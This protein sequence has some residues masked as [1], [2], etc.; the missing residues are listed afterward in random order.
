MVFSKTWFSIVIIS[1][2]YIIF[3]LLV[4]GCSVDLDD[5][6][7]TEGTDDED[8]TDTD[9]PPGCEEAIIFSDPNLESVVRDKINMPTGN[10]YLEDVSEIT[11]LIT[12]LHIQIA[13][14]TGIQCLT[15]LTELDLLN[16]IR[17]DFITDIS[18]LSGLTK[19]TSLSLS[20]NAI[21]DINPLSELTNLESLYLSANSITD[22]NPLSG[23]TNLTSL[24]LARNTVTDISPLIT[25]TNLRT[26]SLNYNNIT[27]IAVL[28]RLVK[29]ELLALRENTITDIGPL[30]TNSGIDNGDILLITGNPIYCA[31]QAN[32]IQELESRGLAEFEHDC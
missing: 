31:E 32:N 6:A 22:I 18:P 3:M 15:N 12:A 10:I 17:E 23:L 13:D 14:L 30:V 19:L 25:L 16:D 26:L 27:D 5:N 8:N 2:L 11:I 24:G 1:I 20:H 28:N 4:Q 21:T 7:D 9:V 29:L